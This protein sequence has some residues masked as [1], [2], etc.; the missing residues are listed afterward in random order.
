MAITLQGRNTR[1]ALTV[2]CNAN[3]L[4]QSLAQLPVIKLNATEQDY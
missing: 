3:K 2:Q 4:R 1:R